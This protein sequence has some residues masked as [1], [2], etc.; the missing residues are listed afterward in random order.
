MPTFTARS[1]M[2]APAEEVYAWH[3]RPG[4]FPRLQPPWE[5]FD[6]APQQGT[7]GTDGMRVTFRTHSLWPVRKTWVVEVYGFDPGRGFAYRQ[8]RGP[9]AEWVHEHRFIPTADGNSVLEN[10]I[11][12]RVP[13]GAAG[14]LVGDPV[15]RRRLNAMFAY[16]HAVT[17][18]DL[19]RHGL[20]RDRPRLTVAVTGSRGLVGSELVTFLTT[21]GHAVVRLVTGKV[22]A[23]PDDGT[24][25]V[26]WK[27]QEPLDPATLAGCDAVVHLAG[28]NVA[29]GRWAEAKKQRIRD[30]RVI[31]TRFLAEAIAALPPGR[32]PKVFVSAS[33][34][35]L[36]GTHGDEVRTEESAAGTGF[37]A[38]V[39]R[40]WEAATGPAAAAG[41]RVVNLRVG[42]VL[43]P[44]D[45]ALGKQLPAFRAGG[46]AVLGDGRQ[47]LPW[48][49]VHDLV[50]AIHHS[51]MTDAVR[52]VVNGVGPNPVT[53]RAFTKTLA[54][55]LRR[56]A[57]LRLPGFALRTLFGPMADEALLA[58]TRAVP[59]KLPATGFTFDHVELEPAL[60][61]LLGKA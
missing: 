45:G 23:S 21:G 39:C 56:P 28:D 19:R 37:L 27:P 30:S 22:S 33:G 52:G 13:F 59:G 51:L 7:F 2:P 20:Y 8:L 54:R 1:P 57:V 6:T 17:A 31:P 10:E 3:A 26:P 58:S 42:L 50:G 43:S 41:V 5:R 60:R 46:G 32:R 55:V 53:N 38:D 4:A 24:R 15:V 12:Y 34:I 9:F 14:R 44:K 36:A 48:V 25:Y 47:W 18:S 49:T 61:F 11:A 16:R 35:S 29:D 40:D